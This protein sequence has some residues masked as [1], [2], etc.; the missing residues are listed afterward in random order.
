MK[1]DKNTSLLDAIFCK[2]IS[3]SEKF[4][5]V[6]DLDLKLCFVDQIIVSQKQKTKNNMGFMD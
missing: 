2:I 1:K 4:I 3:E 6:S 5:G